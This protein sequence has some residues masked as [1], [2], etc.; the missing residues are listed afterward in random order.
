MRRGTGERERDWN[1]G[2][3]LVL[4]HTREGETGALPRAC[5]GSSEVAA[6]EHDRGSVVRKR[7]LQLG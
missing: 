7:G 2:V 5:H 1:D 3:L 6:A 4:K